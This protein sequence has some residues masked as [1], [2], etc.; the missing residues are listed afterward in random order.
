MH[1]SHKLWITISVFLVVI[2]FLL[3][4]YFTATPDKVGSVIKKRQEE[5]MKKKVSGKTPNEIALSRETPVSEE[6]VAAE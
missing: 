3:G 1:S 4:M 2:A 5:K 6:P